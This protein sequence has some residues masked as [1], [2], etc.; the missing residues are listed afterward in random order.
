MTTDGDITFPSGS[1]GN[2]VHT[3][4]EEYALVQANAYPN[5]TDGVVYLSY[6]LLHGHP[7]VTVFSAAGQSVRKVGQLHNQQL[8]L[9]GLL[10]GLYPLQRRFPDGTMAR[11]RVVL[12]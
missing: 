7:E 8:P 12:Q 6:P 3:R 5:P 4:E 10:R 11:T 2:Y 1:L 9:S